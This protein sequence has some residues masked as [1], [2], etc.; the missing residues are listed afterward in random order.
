MRAVAAYPSERRIELVDI[1][2]PAIST[3]TQ[4]KLRMLEVGICGTDRE[5]ASFNYGDPP[6]GSP[7]LVMGHE[8]L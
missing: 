1:P 2:E 5:I 4:L 8:S 7:F 6:P 3:A